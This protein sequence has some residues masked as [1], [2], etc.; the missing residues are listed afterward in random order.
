MIYLLFSVFLFQFLENSHSHDSLL[1]PTLSPQWDGLPWS[2]STSFFKE[3]TVLFKILFLFKNPSLKTSSSLYWDTYIF[4]LNNL[5]IIPSSSCQ[6]SYPSLASLAAWAGVL[7][8]GKGEGSFPH[9]LFSDFVQ[10]PLGSNL[11]TRICTYFI[12]F[13]TIPSPSPCSMCVLN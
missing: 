4:I 9:T 12:Y 3:L 10:A 11:D 13:I 6:V 5:G 7:P 2:F 1:P 8:A